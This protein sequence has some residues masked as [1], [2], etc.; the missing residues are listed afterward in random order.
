M[1]QLCAQ[2]VHHS[3][4]CII[5]KINVHEAFIT[6]PVTWTDSSSTC[7]VLFKRTLLPDIMTSSSTRDFVISFQNVS[8]T[9]FIFKWTWT[10]LPE[11]ETAKRP[12][13]WI[14]L[15]IFYWLFYEI[16][17]NEIYN[18]YNVIFTVPPKYHSW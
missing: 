1:L 12:S 17:A 5:T 8:N 3:L 16:L 10:T 18:Q 9:R 2:G 4:Y 6:A 7:R 15:K 13:S 14:L 11:L